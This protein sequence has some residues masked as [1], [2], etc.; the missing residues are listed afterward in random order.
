MWKK[1]IPRMDV[2]AWLILVVRHGMQQYY[3]HSR[4]QKVVL[5]PFQIV[6]YV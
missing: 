5:F 6:L 4:T 2:G 3:F 1:Q